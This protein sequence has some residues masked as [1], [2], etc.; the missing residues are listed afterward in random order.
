MA[1]SGRSD[2]TSLQ[3]YSSFGARWR[4]ITEFSRVGKEQ[5]AVNVAFGSEL[6]FAISFR[7]CRSADD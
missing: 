7:I 1:A 4:C 6:R 3:S 2:A 5:F